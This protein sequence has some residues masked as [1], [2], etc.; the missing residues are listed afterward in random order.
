MKNQGAVTAQHAWM[1]ASAALACAVAACAHVPDAH[2]RALIDAR[3][4]MHAAGAALVA[5]GCVM[6]ASGV[7]QYYL[8]GDSRRVASIA[9][10]AGGALLRQQNVPL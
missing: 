4:K 3:A 8:I 5:D 10:K 2:E 1:R 6:R 9:A 7:E